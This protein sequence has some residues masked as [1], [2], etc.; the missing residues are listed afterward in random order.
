MTSDDRTSSEPATA[1]IFL[2]MKGQDSMPP[3][4][5]HCGGPYQSK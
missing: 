3:I 5:K 2:F 4:L 1:M